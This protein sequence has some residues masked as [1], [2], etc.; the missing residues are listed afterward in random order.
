[1]DIS[2]TQKGLLL[3]RIGMIAEIAVLIF[4][5]IYLAISWPFITG[6]QESI[7]ASNL[8]QRAN[9]IASISIFMMIFSIIIFVAGIILSAISIKRFSSAARLG[10]V[11]FIIHFAMLVIAS[12]ITGASPWAVYILY[13]FT[14]PG[15]WLGVIF[16]FIS[17]IFLWLGAWRLSREVPWMRWAKL[18]AQAIVINAL[19]FI[20]S[21]ILSN[22][23][24][25][26]A[27]Q[28][29]LLLSMLT[30][31][32]GLVTTY[33][34]TIISCKKS[35]E[36]RA[37]QI[38]AGEKITDDYKALKRNCIIVGGIYIILLILA[39]I[40]PNKEQAMIKEYNERLE[41]ERLE[42]QYHNNSDD[43][44]TP[45]E[46]PAIESTQNID[47]NTDQVATTESRKIC[48]ISGTVGQY[49]I[50]M[51]LTIEGN[52][53]VSGRYRYT[54]TGSQDWIDLK[55]NEQDNGQT[56]EI[57]EEYNGNVTG[58]WNIIGVYSNGKAN[59]IGTMSTP[60]R[61]FDV[62]LNGTYQ[63]AN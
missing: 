51:Q 20:I 60:K 37:A 55:G 7:A 16:T 13:H 6:N 44:Y 53:N 3:L 59:L 9:T 10:A 15:H 4:S 1:M 45:Y 42:T 12:I 19:L 17:Y 5:I 24:G 30:L 54:K 39:I 36:K 27:T 48:L 23:S 26:F 63:P 35:L 2:K 61:E 29:I 41:R 43:S 31:I 34:F 52:G 58:T 40:I 49:P 32:A 14:A 22:H 57:Y 25:N 50:E 11:F 18:G 21:A 38:E 46:I 56:I 47:D 33:V 28:I 8:M 62:I